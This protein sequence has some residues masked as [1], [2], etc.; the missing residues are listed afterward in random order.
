MSFFIRIIRDA[1]YVPYKNCVFVWSFASQNIHGFL[2]DQFCD[3][4]PVKWKILA[5]E[6]GMEYDE[7]MN[8]VST[9][10]RRIYLVVG[11]F[12]LIVMVLDFNNRIA[13]LT[14]LRA[15]SEAENNQLIAMQSTESY[16]ETQIAYATSE[17]AVEGWAREGHFDQ[18]GDFPVIPIPDPEFTPQPEVTF[19]TETEQLSNWDA[20]LLWLFGGV[21]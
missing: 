11:L 21:P 18:P 4:L 16:L 14:R 9:L 13:D 5:P 12:I 7:I 1:S 6:I 19:Y 10:K 15:Q 20:W 8:W 3:S 17:A 2:L